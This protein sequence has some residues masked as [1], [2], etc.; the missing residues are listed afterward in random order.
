MLVSVELRWFWPDACPAQVES[1]FGSKPPGGEATKAPR[2][3]RYVH[4]KGNTEIGIKVR[5]ERRDV[6]PDVEIKGLVALAQAVRLGATTA[7][8]E[9][10]CKWKAGIPLGG[11]IVTKKVRWLRKFAVQDG[12][13]SEVE[14][15]A[16]EKPAKGAPPAVGCNLELTHL[17]VVGRSEA[18]WTV[19]FEAFG[20][21]T[22]AP[23][24]LGSARGKPAA[25][26]RIVRTGPSVRAVAVAHPLGRDRMWLRGPRLD[27]PCASP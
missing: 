13:V 14:L 5:G 27:R 26:V 8:P 7:R 12:G 16:D 15:G 11:G 2:I 21:L 6:P 18:W 20:D 17:R 19:C 25:T 9:I 23:D 3:D 4:Q 24:A 22:T 1:W 10:W